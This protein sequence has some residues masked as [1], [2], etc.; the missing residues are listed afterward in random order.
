ME[1]ADKAKVS[2]YA[3]IIEAVFQRY[4]KKGKTEFSFERDELIQVCRELT[5]GAPHRHL[6]LPVIGRACQSR[7]W[8]PNRR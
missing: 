5:T 6:P 1:K 2:R 7:Y 3:S 8:Q 4:W